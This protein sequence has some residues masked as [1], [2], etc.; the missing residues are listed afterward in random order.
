MKTSESKGSMQNGGLG[1]RQDLAGVEVFSCS[2][3]VPEVTEIWKSFQSHALEE[4]AKVESRLSLG[5]KAKEEYTLAEV[6]ARFQK[7]FVYNRLASAREKME[8]LHAEIQQE[9]EP[10]EAA[11]SNGDGEEDA[12][13]QMMS[14]RLRA[15]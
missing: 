10:I 8:K 14:S 15:Q 9:W 7:G 13:I 1:F 12:Q 6:R 11:G 3:G 4:L 2:G 5:L